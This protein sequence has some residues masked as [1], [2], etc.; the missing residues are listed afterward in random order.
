MVAIRTAKGAEKASEERQHSEVDA[1]LDREVTHAIRIT[2]R[3][4]HALL[5]KHEALFPQRKEPLLSPSEENS[6]G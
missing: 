6:P 4:F 3:V 1:E 2:V 5:R